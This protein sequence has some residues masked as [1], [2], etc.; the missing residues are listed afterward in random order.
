MIFRAD[1]L[2]DPGTKDLFVGVRGGCGTKLSRK[3][4]YQTLCDVAVEACKHG[5]L[6]PLPEGTILVGWVD[7][8]QGSVRLAPGRHQQLSGAWGE[9]LDRRQLN[10]VADEREHDDRQRFRRAV[11]TGN[12]A[13]MARLGPRRGWRW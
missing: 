11:I 12:R 13:E 6:E 7:A 8:S 1:L 5:P 9:F 10:S 3:D 4:R 2:F